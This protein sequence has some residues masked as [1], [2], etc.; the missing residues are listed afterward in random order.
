MPWAVLVP[1]ADVNHRSGR[2][3]D[4][5]LRALLVG[6]VFLRYYSHGC[7]EI[8]ADGLYP[9]VKIYEWRN[10]LLK[11]EWF[12]LHHHNSSP[13]SCHLFSDLVGILNALGT[14]HEDT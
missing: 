6:H 14:S 4:S 9:A 10:S 13:L 5:Y 7:Q 8:C 1:K 12:V 3:A 2:V 11:Q